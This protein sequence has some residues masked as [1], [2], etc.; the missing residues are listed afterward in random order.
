MYHT[1]L[2]LFWTRC[3]SHTN[4]SHKYKEPYRYHTSV[5]DKNDTHEAA[6]CEGI[7][8]DVWHEK[9]ERIPTHNYAKYLTS[10]IKWTPI[11]LLVCADRRQTREQKENRIHAHCQLLTFTSATIFFYE[12]FERS[13]LESSRSNCFLLD[14][15]M[16]V[17]S[18]WNMLLHYPT[19]NGM[20]R[21][22]SNW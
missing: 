15:S 9:Q 6:D 13:M 10:N 11:S 18:D 1:E 17:G 4:H 8:H 16:R 3:T 12:T 2:I 7:R 14:F 19:T 20:Y 21:G 5:V 22:A